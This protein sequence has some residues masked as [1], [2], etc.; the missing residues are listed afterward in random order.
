MNTEEGIRLCTYVMQDGRQLQI[1][2]IPRTGVDLTSR[3]RYPFDDCEIIDAM[4]T[5]NLFHK[6]GLQ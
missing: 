4:V 5:E 1:V 6:Y 2:Y 3:E